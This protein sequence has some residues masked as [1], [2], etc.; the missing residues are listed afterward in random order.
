MQ[1][2]DMSMEQLSIFQNKN[3]NQFK[4]VKL[5][6]LRLGDKS[7]SSTL[8]DATSYQT[9]LEATIEKLNK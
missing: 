7:R 4:E 8:S 1:A 9:K 5:D 2:L 3:V 6:R